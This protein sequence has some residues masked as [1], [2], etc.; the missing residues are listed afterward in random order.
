MISTELEF[1]TGRMIGCLSNSRGSLVKDGREKEFGVT[2]SKFVLDVSVVIVLF[3][4]AA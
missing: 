4:V 3:Y 1:L 2:V